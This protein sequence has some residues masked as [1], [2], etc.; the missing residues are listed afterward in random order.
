MMDFAQ[1]C[2]QA[3]VKNNSNLTFFDDDEVLLE[4]DKVEDLLNTSPPTQRK[5]DALQRQEHPQVLCCAVRQPRGG[6]QH[7]RRAPSCPSGSSTGC[8]LPH[9]A[10]APGQ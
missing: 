3:G 10:Q 6:R 4:K 9:E 1:Q 5:G 2:L 7:C 8:Q